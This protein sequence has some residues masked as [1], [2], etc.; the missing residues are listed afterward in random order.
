M[1]RRRVATF[2]LAGVATLGLFMASGPTPA[3]AGSNGQYLSLRDVNNLAAS[4]IV[5]G[6]NQACHFVYY[7]IDA[8]MAHD[9]DLTGWWFQSWNGCN[10]YYYVT[11]WTYAGNTLQGGENGTYNL[12][13][14]P[15]SQSS[16]W[17]TCE[18]DGGSAC[19]A[20]DKAFG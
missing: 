14:P 20:G 12:N 3:A 8:W 5:G 6:D 19:K 18:V 4:A 11:V 15:H 1:V 17:W 13:G 10:P 2:L 7:T 9:F 16:N